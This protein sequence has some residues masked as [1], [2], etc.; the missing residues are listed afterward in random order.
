MN[1][2]FKKV[3][4]WGYLRKVNQKDHKAEEGMEDDASD[5]NL[6]D[7]Q[8]L[9]LLSNFD[10]K[11][12]YK[13]DDFFDTISLRSRQKTRNYMGSYNCGRGYDYGGGAVGICISDAI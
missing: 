11:P 9:G 1:E 8:G 10:V 13:K 6:V 4:V 2:K 12:S 5:Q 3:E 7:K